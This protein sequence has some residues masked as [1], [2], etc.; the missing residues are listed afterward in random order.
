MLLSPKQEF[1][2]AP[3]MPAHK[4]QEHTE[5]RTSPRGKV[6]SLSN[7]LQSRCHKTSRD[8]AMAHQ[9]MFQQHIQATNRPIIL[10][11]ETKKKCQQSS[12]DQAHP[13]FTLSHTGA[14]TPLNVPVILFLAAERLPQITTALCTT[15]VPL[16]WL[17]A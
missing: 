3:S 5:A 16:P 2:T 10:R 12:T 1:L 7:R 8:S 13:L 4:A 17:L 9:M 15:V 6:L 14:E 11:K